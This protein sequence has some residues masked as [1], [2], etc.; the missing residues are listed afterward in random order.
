[1]YIYLDF[2]CISYVLIFSEC[3]TKF[4]SPLNNRNL[5][6]PSSRVLKCKITVPTGL[7]SGECSL[8][9][10]HT[11][12]FSLCPHGLSLLLAPQEGEVSYSH[13]LVIKPLSY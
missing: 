11:A 6:S 7:V 3:T 2:A 1:M 13:T 4:H 8:P 9:S 5:F 10:L 12:L